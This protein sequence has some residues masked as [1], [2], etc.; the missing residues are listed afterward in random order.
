[1][2]RKRATLFDPKTFLTKV[3]G[4]KKILKC[5]KKQTLFSQ[6]ER[7]GRRILSPR[8][9][10]SSSPSSPPKAKKPSLRF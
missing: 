8:P 1:M 4:G 9:A 3:D 2:G 7:G 5:R 10:K 6:G